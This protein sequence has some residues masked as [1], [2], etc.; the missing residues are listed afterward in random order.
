MS[1]LA[2]SNIRY[3]MASPFSQPSLPSVWYIVTFQH[4]MT[5]AGP[6]LSLRPSNL[7]CSKSWFQELTLLELSTFSTSKGFFITLYGDSW[8]KNHMTF[9][10][11]LLAFCSSSILYSTGSIMENGMGRKRTVYAKVVWGHSIMHTSSPTSNRVAN[12]LSHLIR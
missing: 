3:G 8:N 2:Q 9:L 5:I 6:L 11:N 1:P 10:P 4:V 12:Y 7:F